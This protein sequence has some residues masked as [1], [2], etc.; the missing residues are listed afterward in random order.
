M[1]LWLEL[2]CLPFFGCLNR[3]FWALFFV[4]KEFALEGGG[5][6]PV[7][8]FETKGIGL[9]GILEGWRVEDL[10]M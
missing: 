9:E 7:I 3:Q 5:Y 4:S 2:A 8:F 6:L 1:Y 10:E